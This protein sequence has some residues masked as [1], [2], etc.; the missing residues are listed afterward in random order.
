RRC[1]HPELAKPGQE[2]WINVAT[3]VTEVRRWTAGQTLENAPVFEHL[4]AKIRF[5]TWR[6]VT[7]CMKLDINTSTRDVGN[8]LGCHQME[9]SALDNVSPI[10]AKS[11]SD[12]GKPC[13]L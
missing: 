11:G 13:L 2:Q 12:I 7:M 1:F 9:Y 5:F 8:L 6:P 10:D 3:R 4:V